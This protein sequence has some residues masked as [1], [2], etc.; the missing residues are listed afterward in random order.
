MSEYSKK[1]K[2]QYAREKVD[3]ALKIISNELPKIFNNEKYTKLL[4]LISKFHEQSLNNIILISIQ[5][6]EATKL[7]NYND[8]QK[9]KRQVKRNEKGIVVLVPMQN[10]K[11]AKVIKIDEFG[12]YIKNDNGTYMYESIRFSYLVF[13]ALN[14][15]DIS[16]TEEVTHKDNVDIKQKKHLYLNC[17]QHLEKCLLIA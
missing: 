12:E 6:P 17:F 14:F 1:E 9:L 2:I 5:Y 7:A 4:T 3:K 8:W 15:F 10:K 13:Y 11:L 16:Q